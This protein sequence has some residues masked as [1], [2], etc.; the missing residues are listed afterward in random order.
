MQLLTA[1]LRCPQPDSLLYHGYI[2]R[3]PKE[4]VMRRDNG[5]PRW[6]CMWFLLFLL[7]LTSCS[8][9][10]T[11]Q[12]FSGHF[13]SMNTG[14][15]ASIKRLSAEIGNCPQAKKYSVSWRV[16]LGPNERGWRAVKYEREDKTSGYVGYEF[17]PGSGF[18]RDIYLVDDDAIQK[19]AQEAGSL[20]DFAKYAK[21]KT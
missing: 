21:T 6:T 5:A 4:T 1:D 12:A 8:C 11:V 3:Q 14:S 9:P 2:A 18:G 13:D 17:D 7:I 15:R 16:D 19:V 10:D 20:E